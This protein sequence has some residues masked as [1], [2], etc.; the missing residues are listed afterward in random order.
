MTPGGRRSRPL[1]KGGSRSDIGHDVPCSIAHHE[2]DQEALR[3][4]KIAERS[5]PELLLRTC[6]GTA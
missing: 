2:I 3:L 1:G 4:T 6:G 5:A